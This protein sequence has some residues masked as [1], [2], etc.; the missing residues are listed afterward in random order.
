M[1]GGGD[2][3]MI[4][5]LHGFRARSRRCDV[6][7]GQMSQLPQDR[8]SRPWDGASGGGGAAVPPGRFSRGRSQA[9]R[10]ARTKVRPRR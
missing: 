5:D 2:G 1:L 8:G 7:S 3:R 4:Q 6:R 9:R 10:R